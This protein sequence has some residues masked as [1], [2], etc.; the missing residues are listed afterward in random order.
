[1]REIR[2]CLPVLATT[3]ILSACA[4]NRS[5]GTATA[6]SSTP[7]SIT[8]TAAPPPGGRGNARSGP[9]SGGAIG[10]VGSVS[11]SS[12][13]LS[14]SAGVNL[15]VNTVPS[16]TYRKG[17]RS[18]SASAVTTGQDVLVLG[19]TDGTTITATQIVV[20]RT[21]GSGSAAAPAAAVIPFQRGTPAARQVGQIPARYR[22]GSGTIISGTAA[23]EATKAA[24]GAYPGGLIDRVVQIAD[25]EYEVH[26]IGVGWPHHIF[27]DQKFK[28]VGAD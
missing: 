28:F 5:R 19:T 15:T 14:T 22:Q 27:I 26:N 17:A 20:Q 21:H 8:A 12:F 2:Y 24:L 6:S 11:T 1:M 7:T 23:T 9:A 4:G 25:G 3:A 10:R 16:T 13:A 18:T